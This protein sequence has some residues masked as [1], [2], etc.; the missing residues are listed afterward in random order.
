MKVEYGD[1]LF[2]NSGTR[3][4]ARQDLVIIDTVMNQYDVHKQFDIRSQRD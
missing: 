3:V 2:L 4:A 1:S